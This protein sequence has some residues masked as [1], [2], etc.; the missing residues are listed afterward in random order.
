MN[1]NRTRFEIKRP[2]KIFFFLVSLFSLAGIIAFY[3]LLTPLPSEAEPL[4]FYATPKRDDLKLTLL[5]AIRKAQHSIWI[6][7]YGI[8]DKEVLAMLKKKAAAGVRVDLVYHHSINRQ[9]HRQERANFH[10]H[11][12]KNKGLMHEKLLITDDTLL[13]FGST[14]LTSSSLLMH[15]NC[16]LGLYAPGL[17][18]SLKYERLSHYQQRLNKQQ[19]D[20]F[21]LPQGGGQALKKLLETLDQAKHRV[22]IALFT[23]THPALVDKLIALHQRGIQIQLFL[24]QYTARAASKKAVAKLRAAQIPVSISQGLALFHHKWALVDSDTLILGS[25]NWT[26]KAF[27]KNNELL[28]FLTPLSKAH[29][30]S[31]SRAIKTFKL[32]TTLA[33]IS[34]KTPGNLGS[35]VSPNIPK[36][37]PG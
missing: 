27:K 6:C 17:A 9:L 5:R 26:R 34:H 3:A 16:L 2:V 8:S 15:D 14:N 33:R 32:E 13:F 21:I 28:L 18:S 19:L 36:D 20:L 22:S 30:R 10:C 1:R 4:I 7:S 12:K 24:D 35:S 31:F 25:A 29:A 37:S 23:L 11:P